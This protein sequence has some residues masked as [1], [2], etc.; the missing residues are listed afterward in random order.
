MLYPSEDTL[1]QTRLGQ[2]SRKEIHRS[3]GNKKFI[4]YVI[5]HQFKW[6]LRKA[7]FFFQ[8]IALLDTRYQITFCK[9]TEADIIP[10]RK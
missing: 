9:S 4:M 6:L 10:D 7:F 2:A 8:K 1:H 3:T 5:L